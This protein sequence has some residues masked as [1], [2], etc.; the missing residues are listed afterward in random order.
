MST[1]YRLL[2]I[3]REGAPAQPG[4]LVGDTILDLGQVAGGPVSAGSTLELLE[5]WDQSHPWLCELADAVAAGKHGAACRPLAETALDAPILYPSSVFCIASNYAAHSKE[6]GNTKPMPDK[7]INAPVWF[8]K[9]PRQTIVGDG[10]LVH[11]P[12][13]ST[14]IDW[15]SEVAVVIGRP[16]FGASKG[17]AFDFVAGYTILNDMSVR[18]PSAAQAKTPQ[19]EAFRRDRFRRKNWDGSAPM[20]P[21]ITPKEFIADIYDQPIRLWLNGEQMQDG[22]SGEMWWRIEEQIAYLS[23]HLTLS[24]G[25][26]I[27]TGTP[28]GV[29]KGRGLYLK[30]GDEISTTIGDLGT[31]R[32]RFTEPK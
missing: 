5:H 1:V 18:G 21:W 27:S 8:Q 26:V 20:G 10:S 19:D 29:G 7:S 30:P 15:E 14:A 28:A 3:R 17:S 2:N 12:R 6:M 11:L 22:N 16:A 31:L 24:P 23:E 9:T 32:I 13:T 25:D 4:I